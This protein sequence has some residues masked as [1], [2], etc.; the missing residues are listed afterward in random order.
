MFADKEFRT[1][2]FGYHKEDVQEYIEVLKKKAS[3]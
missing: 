1:V 3:V 2:I